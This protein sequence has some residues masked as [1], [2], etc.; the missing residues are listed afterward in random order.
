MKFFVTSFEEIQYNSKHYWNQEDLH[1]K[2]HF[3]I[4][5]NLSRF[6]YKS[7]D[8]KL[9]KLILQASSETCKLIVDDMTPKEMLEGHSWVVVENSPERLSTSRA[10]A[11]HILS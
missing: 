11:A 5:F 10:G 6:Q 8:S 9:T 1:Y 3:M 2:F 7:L 4:I